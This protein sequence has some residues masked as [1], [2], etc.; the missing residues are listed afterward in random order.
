MPTRDKVLIAVVIVISLGIL[1][2]NHDGVFAA[3]TSEGGFD[4]TFNVSGATNLNVENS[5][6]SVNVHPGSSDKVE[7]HAKVRATNWFSGSD[8]EIQKIEK[9]PPVEQTGNTIRI[10]RPEPR[11]TFNHV[12]ISYDISVPEETIVN[13]STGSGS[14]TIAGVKGPVEARSGSGS[15]NLSNIGS[16]VK[17]RTGSGHISLDRINGKADVQTGSGGVNANAVAG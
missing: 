6:G 13:S 16:E 1:A 4:R 3:G 12:S 8:D 11:D 14:Q 5:S 2:S 10:Y 7:I 17:A 15:V 9:N